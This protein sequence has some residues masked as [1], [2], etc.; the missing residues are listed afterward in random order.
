MFRVLPANFFVPL[1]SQN[2]TV[3]W[4]CICKLFSVMEHQLSFGVERDVLVDELEY[5]FD[6]SAAADL[7]E[8]EFAGADSRG[9][10]NGVL[11]RLEYYGWL[12]VET[13][14]SYVQ[15]VNFKEYAVRLMKTLLEIE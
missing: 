3:Y 7:A 2:K 4:D 12:E 9:K 10:A 6:Q 15:R 8:E 14:K 13:D 11:R 5:Y 1:S